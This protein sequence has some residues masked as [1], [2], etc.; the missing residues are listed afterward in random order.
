MIDTIQAGFRLLMSPFKMGT[1]HRQ[2]MWANQLEMFI[3]KFCDLP[4]YFTVRTVGWADGCE[5]TFQFRELWTVQLE[6]Q[7]GP[8]AIGREFS[9]PEWPTYEQ[10]QAI[11]L[12]IKARHDKT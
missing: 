7:I 11:I 4:P 9:Y 10:V 8:R 5:P 2:Q 12:D 1:R 6:F 3:K